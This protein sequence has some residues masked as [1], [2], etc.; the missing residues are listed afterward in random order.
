M[1]SRIFESLGRLFSGGDTTQAKAASAGQRLVAEGGA[2][3][4][5]DE[6]KRGG[7]GIVYLCHFDSDKHSSEGRV[8]LKTFDDRYFFDVEMSDT[9]QREHSLW[10]LVADVPFVLPVFGTFLIDKKPHLAMVVADGDGNGNVSLRDAVEKSSGGGLP[11]EVYLPA[12]LCV[13]I[14][15]TKVSE[16]VPGLVHGDIKPDNVLYVGSRP[17]LSDFGLAGIA[18]RAGR[19]G[20]PPYMAPE[21]WTDDGRQTA[22]TDIYAYGVMLAELIMGKAPLQAPK[23]DLR[24][25]AQAHAK[26]QP[27]I[28]LDSNRTDFNAACSLRAL[29]LRCLAKAPGNRPTDFASIAMEVTS[30]V[31]EHDPILALTILEAAAWLSHLA[32]EVQ[33]KVANG[34]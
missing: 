1:I 15:M 34:R 28:D 32:R 31:L 4:V 22:A 24:L 13:A 2:V 5:V 14:A 16:R 20:T 33:P 12:A 30:A 19:R 10:T 27:R 21:L 11:P 26:T 18:N 8:A 7:M 3:F 17:F 9:F 6:V 23:D 29:A 25:W